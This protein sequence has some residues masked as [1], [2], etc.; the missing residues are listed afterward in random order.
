MAAPWERDWSA[1]SPGP[2]AP[3]AAGAKPWQRKWGAV[4]D[5]EAPLVAGAREIDAQESA[6]PAPPPE[7]T[8]LERAG[9]QFGLGTRAALSG[10]AALPGVAYD[11]AGAV[12]NVGIMGLNAL[13]ADL[14]GVRPFRENSQAV[15]TAAGL[16]EAETG[17]ERGVGLTV[18]GATAALPSL[19]LGI[20]GLSGLSTARATPSLARE[21]AEMLAA[22]PKSQIASGAASGAAMGAAGEA[23]DQ[24]PYAMGVAGFLGAFAPAGAVAAV[25]PWSA[26]KRTRMSD[27][28]SDFEAS[29][30]GT[31]TVSQA[32]GGKMAAGMESV[33]S[34]SPG[35]VSVMAKAMEKQADGLAAKMDDVSDGRTMAQAG[36]TIQ[37]GIEGFV[38]RFRLRSGAMFKAFERYIPPT[39]A[40]TGENTQDALARLTNPIPGAPQVGAV[41]RN[42]KIKQISDAFYADAGI[43][44]PPPGTRPQDT[45]TAIIPFKAL[46]D[47]RIKIGSMIGGN[48]LISG[49]PRSEL[50]QL[51]AALSED[52]KVA[53]GAAGPD[54]ARAFNRAD[55][56][57]RSGLGRVESTLN[58]F[59][60]MTDPAEIFKAAVRD[61]TSTLWALRR[62]VKPREW[63]VV[64]QAAAG[65][66]G[67]ARN[68]SQNAAG[69]AFS[70][71][72]FLTNYNKLGK[73][74]QDAL[75]GGVGEGRASMAEDLRAIARSVERVR[76]SNKVLSNPSGTAATVAN[77]TA[78]TIFLTSLLRG[79]VTTMATM[80]AAAGGIR[81][82]AKLMTS[83]KF[84]RW[85]AEAQR[86]PV[87]RAPAL[88]ARLSALAED[89]E[90][91]RDDVQAFIS[92]IQSERRP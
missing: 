76:A 72:T 21:G 79:D 65:Q 10:L 58:R 90:E 83:P 46:R 12:T 31:P 80:G 2:A 81:G 4:L 63:E 91:I 9:R 23:T 47:L 6:A 13:G 51:Y 11:A 82:T 78:G 49:I 18:E 22:A 29:G 3:A 61:D 45:T 84:V 41:V 59:A 38:D 39:T 14:P 85:L 53:A 64:A 5:T 30:A 19:G 75:F 44:M 17:W 68:A 25:K 33:L 36:R 50:K 60:E 34:R 77:I 26:A 62:S 92:A 8:M 54:A 35:G 88:L 24:N 89:D 57:Y 70:A 16:P 27:A 40:V 67:L 7:P 37:K 73:G 15:M 56:F 48:E 86:F 71:E 42:Q 43:E 28:I 1:P 32:T 55:S 87:E 74:T 66:L 52:M 20:A 69:D